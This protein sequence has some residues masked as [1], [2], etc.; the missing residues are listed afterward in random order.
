MKEQITIK[1]LKDYVD[2]L[3]TH[4][5]DKMILFRGQREDKT[6][7]PKIAR[8]KLREVEKLLETEQTMF[9]EFKKKSR[10][11]LESKPDSDW[12][13]LAMA[14]HHGMATRLLDWT[15]NPLAGLW[16]A[17]R[18][19]PKKDKDGNIKN[20]VVW[21]FVV[22]KKYIVDDKEK[23]SPFEGQSTKVFQPN[24]ITKS[25]VAQQGWFTVHK[26]I[27][28][29]SK[30]IPF[31]RLDAYNKFLTKLIIPGR[32]FCEIRY[33]L[34]RCGINNASLFPDLDGLCE[35]IV[36]DNSLLQDEY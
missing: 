10:P 14:Q 34:D 17:V 1:C 6:L 22:N 7:L 19:P 16:F 24:H 8:I 28:P 35:H 3:T 5:L 36:W 9:N 33:D 23:I 13:W 15:K 27:E 25:I 12:D 20:G 18:R 31:E 32:I 30:F 21:V 4:H 2:Y 26:Y 29:K 11:F